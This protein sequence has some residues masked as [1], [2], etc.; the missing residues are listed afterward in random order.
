MQMVDAMPNALLCVDELDKSFG[1]AHENQAADSGVASRVLSYFLN[2][3]VER[4]VSSNTENRVFVLATLNR[5]AG[6][7]PELLRAGRFDR[8]WSVDLPDKDERAEILAIHLTKR[9]VPSK[10]YGK[11]LMTVV[12]A[13]DQFTGAELEEVVISARNDAYDT[14]MHTWETADKKG[15]PPTAEQIRPTVEE[16]LTAASE[17][18][19]VAKLDVES[20]SAIR[21]FCAECCYPVN[22][23]R[24][25]N[26]TRTRAN[27]KVSTE[28]TSSDN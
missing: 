22:G 3:L 16:L 23:E 14:R 10:E 12:G 21:K 11:A 25:Q 6:V 4:D 20:I 8:V 24:V 19:P 2:W 18:T 27:R 17:I 15:P 5:T 13:T 28:R 9:G 26:T 7:P 1:G